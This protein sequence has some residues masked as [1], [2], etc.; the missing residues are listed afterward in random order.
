MTN[1]SDAT[2]PENHDAELA[3]LK[4]GWQ[5][6]QA[7]F[8]N[9][10][11]R[12]EQERGALTQRI[13]GDV[14]LEFVPAYD[15]FQRAFAHVSEEHASWADGFRQI[16]KQMEA[17][18]A[19]HGLERIASVGEPFDPAKHEAVSELPNDTY[20]ADTVSEELESGWLCN[21]AV[22]KP[23]KVVVSTGPAPATKGATQ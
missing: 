10:R 21:G 9:F 18:F 12:V 13:A 20:P 4:A 16:A 1:S 17:V 8:E 23:A 3:E 7:D 2:T 11:R 6:T 15:N 5:R 19:A 22:V 14:L